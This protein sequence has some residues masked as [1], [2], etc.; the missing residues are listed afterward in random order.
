VIFVVSVNAALNIIVIYV[1]WKNIIFD[2]MQLSRLKMTNLSRP[3][4]WFGW[5]IETIA[6]VY[7]TD[8]AAKE[9]ELGLVNNECLWAAWRAEAEQ[10]A[11]DKA[12]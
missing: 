12:S 6:A 8:M 7:E 9:A 11:L 1:K 3:L 10:N 2:K 4:N 5:S